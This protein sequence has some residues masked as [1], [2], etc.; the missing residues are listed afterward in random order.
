MLVAYHKYHL[1][2]S[3]DVPYALWK[4][5]WNV[6]FSLTFWFLTAFNVTSNENKKSHIKLKRNCNSTVHRCYSFALR[7]QKELNNQKLTLTKAR[8]CNWSK[9]KTRFNTMVCTQKRNR[10]HWSS[11]I[12]T[13]LKEIN[14][15]WRYSFCIRTLYP[16]NWSHSVLDSYL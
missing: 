15:L 6:H 2:T 9:N 7:T 13:N 3:F 11:S 5:L 4:T 1:T 14:V 12:H 10:I 8:I 16:W